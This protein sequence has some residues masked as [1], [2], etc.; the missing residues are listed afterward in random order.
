MGAVCESICNPASP[1]S[2]SEEANSIA[3][4]LPSHISRN[5]VEGQ[6]IVPVLGMASALSQVVS[7]EKAPLHPVSD[8]EASTLAP[9]DS[10]EL[11]DEDIVKE[12]ICFTGLADDNEELVKI[13][14]REEIARIAALA[15]ITFPS[16]L[17]WA[18]AALGIATR[19]I[20]NAGCAYRD[21][22]WSV[23]FYVLI[24]QKKEMPRLCDFCKIYLMLFCF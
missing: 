4:K 13:R 12:S 7:S 8:D 22:I 2:F 19:D 15:R 14:G 6:L 10:E 23:F 16:K 9:D 5:A 1:K 18:C 21:Q 20:S 24:T 3:C 17:A 11:S